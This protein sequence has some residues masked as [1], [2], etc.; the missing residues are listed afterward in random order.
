MDSMS[1]TLAPLD[2][3]NARAII[4]WRY[5]PPYA[6]YNVL[7]E[8]EVLENLVNFLADPLNRYYSILDE[9]EELVGFCCFGLDAQVPGGDYRVE[10]LDIGLGVRP[11]LTGQGHGMD[12]VLCVLEAASRLF[13]PSKVRVTIAA[14]NTRAQRVWEKVGFQ[15]T[16]RFNRNQDS[17]P[18]VILLKEV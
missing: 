8:G 10:A 18:F 4:G 3:A 7:A 1:H 16:H 14:F 9:R 13:A 5:P 11:D 17:E 15:R 12:F 2:A 6:V